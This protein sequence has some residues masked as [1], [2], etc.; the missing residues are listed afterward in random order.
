MSPHHTKARVGIS[1]ILNIRGMLASSDIKKGE[2]IE[3]CPTILYPISQRAM[4]Q[5]TVIKSYYFL[6]DDEYDAVILGYGSL[7]NH[8]YAPNADFWRD[9]EN[10]TF[11]VE[12]WRDIEKGEE[13]T[14][15]YNGFPE[16][17]DPIG[18][19]YLS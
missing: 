19:E 10:R 8:S 2:I 5:K 11:M 16:V 17:Q 6:W 4:M 15:N 3:S 9:Y 7:Y 13:V 14:I 12:A 1:P 18:V